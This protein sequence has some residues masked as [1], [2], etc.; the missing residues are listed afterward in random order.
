MRTLNAILKRLTVE[1]LAA[2][3]GYRTSTIY[4]WKSGKHKPSKHALEKLENLVALKKF[5]V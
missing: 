4:F 2:T 3:I 1:E 5:K